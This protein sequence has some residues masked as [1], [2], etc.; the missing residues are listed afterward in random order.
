MM[1]PN[2]GRVLVPLCGKS[3]DLMWLAGRGHEV[4]GVELSELACE[5]FFSEQGLVPETSSSGAFKAYEAGGVRLLCGDVFQLTPEDIGEVSAWYDRAALIALSP[6]QRPA[7]ERVMAQVLPSGARGLLIGLAYPPHEKA[8]PP[9]PVPESE[10]TDTWGADFEL[11]V[12]E[13]ADVVD[14]EPR[15]RQAWGLT[16]LIQTLYVLRRR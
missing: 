7:Y 4:T 16:E 14:D 13:R 5:Q 2:G 10:V 1:P 8:G 3:L 9:F 15:F 12:L 6:E 11:E